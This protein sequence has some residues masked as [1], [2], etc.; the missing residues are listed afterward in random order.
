MKALLAFILSMAVPPAIKK[1]VP[2]L[3]DRERVIAVAASQV[4]IT[5]ATGNNDGEPD[6]YLASV[7]LAG[8]HAPYCA[9]YVYW[10]GQQA[11]GERNPYPKSAWSPSQVAGGVRVTEATVI[12]GGETFGIYFPSK[13]RI[14]HTGLIERRDGA[15]F[16]TLE[17]N[18]SA[19]AAVGSA[20]D[21][22]GQGVFRKRRHWRTVHNTKDWMKQ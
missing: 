20:A 6:K 3:T 14:G 15:S 2:V 11:L 13:K 10:V 4:G 21:R 16:I 5:E 19:N 1:P 12:K 22:E 18:T 9:A 7:G 17:A 8:S